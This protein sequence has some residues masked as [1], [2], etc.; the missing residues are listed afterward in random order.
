[1]DTI[2]NRI[3]LAKYFNKLGFKKGA[4]IGVAAGTYSEC[5][6]KEIP[7][8]K[9]FCIDPW[10]PYRGNRRGGGKTLHRQN[11][12]LAQKRLSRYEVAFVRK[13]SMEAVKD[14]PDNSLD[15]V[16]I[17][18]NHDF[19]YVMQDIIEWSKKVRT[20]GIVSGH[21]YFNFRNSGIVEAVDVYVKIH[22]IKLFTIVP[23]VRHDT[24]YDERH[25]CFYWIK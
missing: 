25:P 21:D 6:C 13:F 22:G 7:N 23:E 11:Y 16:F 10:N 15:F 5:L 20:G 9:L 12:E 18:G 3:E 8:L 17:D 24:P 19:D 14:F 2:K 4:E 1:M